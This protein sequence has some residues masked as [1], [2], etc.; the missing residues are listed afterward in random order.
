MTILEY[1]NYRE[2]KPHGEAS[3]P[4]ITYPCSIPLDF[5][6][7]PLHW[8]EKMEIIFIKKGEGLVSVDF[9]NYEVHAGTLLF[10]VPG[11]LHSIRQKAA[12]AMEYENIIFSLEMLKASPIEKSATDYFGPLQKGRLLIPTVITPTHPMYGAIV[13][14]VNGADEICRTFPKAYELAIKAQLYLLFH[15]LFSRCEVEGDGGARRNALDRIR[16]VVKYVENHYMEPLS[17]RDMAEILGLSESHFMKFFKNTMG[18][19]F[20]DYLNDYRLTM[21]SRLLLSSGD[22]VL[23]VAEECGY[24]TLSYFNRLFK[25]R[26]GVTP[27]EYRKT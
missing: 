21:A 12:S 4:Y 7:V 18:E 9:T 17:T 22:S 27:R 25:K 16:P 24:E 2:D 1:E 26:F 13:S 15:I 20:I 14:C 10:I 8:H 11:Q 6:E 5:P 23:M 3:F 19:T